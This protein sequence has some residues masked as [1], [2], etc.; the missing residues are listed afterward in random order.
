MTISLYFA[1]HM[2]H[3]RREETNCMYHVR[4]LY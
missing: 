4:G 2:T 1:K 3:A